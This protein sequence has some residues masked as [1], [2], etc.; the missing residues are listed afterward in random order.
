LISAARAESLDSGATGVGVPAA[1]VDEARRV[2]VLDMNT[3]GK[4]VRLPA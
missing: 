2:V 1:T 3:A 4:Q